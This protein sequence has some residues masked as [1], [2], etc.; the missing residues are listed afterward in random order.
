MSDINS[1]ATPAAQDSPASARLEPGQTA[2]DFTL[3]CDEGGS[4]TLSALHGQNIILYF[5]LPR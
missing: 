2:P 4:I 3:P 5:T 1:P